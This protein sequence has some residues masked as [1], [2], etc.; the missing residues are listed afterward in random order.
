[1]YTTWLGRL[2]RLD[3]RRERQ[4]FVLLSLAFLLIVL[5]LAAATDDA[6]GF[7][8]VALPGSVLM[9]LA[10]AQR[11]RD[12]GLPGHASLLVLLPGVGIG[13]WTA[14]AVAPGTPGPNCHGP[15][16]RLRHLRR[17]LLIEHG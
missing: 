9:V 15:D 11:C 3:G 12:L 10:L 8:A 6:A 17:D 4:S 1:M 13:V 2:L 7:L 14:L 16:P 5:P